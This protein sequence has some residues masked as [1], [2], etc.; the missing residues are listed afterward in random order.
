MLLD[1]NPKFRRLTSGRC[2]HCGVKFFTAKRTG[3]PPLFCG[4]KC[5]QA[6][7]RFIS[8]LRRSGFE[9]EWTA[10]LIRDE[11]HRKTEV[12]SKVS[13]ID[14]GDR[15]LP[16]NVLGNGHRWSNTVTVDRERLAEIVATEIPE[17]RIIRSAA[18]NPYID[19]IPDDLSIPAF[20]RRPS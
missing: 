11:I 13:K 3:R 14:F 16:L 15:P 12:N 17:R 2:Q 9:P 20:L 4:K 1:P 7:F 8:G 10:G 18:P 6:E 5:R 19:E